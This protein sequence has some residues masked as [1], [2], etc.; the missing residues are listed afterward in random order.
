[1]LAYLD[2]RS[3]YLVLVLL[4]IAQALSM[5]YV[6]QMHWNAPH[7]A[8]WARGYSLIALGLCL[9]LASELAAPALLKTL[10]YALIIWGSMHIAFGVALVSR[11]SPQW[12][13]GQALCLVFLL[14]Y[15]LLYAFGLHGL[16]SIVLFSIAASFFFGYAI[17]SCCTAERNALRRPLLVVAMLSA[18][19]GISLIVHLVA[20]FLD[21]AYPSQYSLWHSGALIIN[22]LLGFAQT[23][24][25]MVIA[26]CRQQM[27][28]QQQATRD[29]LT[30]LFNRRALATLAQR[31]IARSNRRGTLISVLMIDV[32]HF[33]KIND[34]YGHAAGDAVLIAIAKKILSGLRTEDVLARYSGDEFLVMLP[35]TSL[36]NA[37]DVAERIRL[38]ISKI[39]LPVLPQAH[40][41][42]VSVGVAERRG[43]QQSFDELVE[44]ADQALYQAKRGGRNKVLGSKPTPAMVF[45]TQDG[46]QASIA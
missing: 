29:P 40:R 28:L 44:L 39:T 45:Q 15:L 11:K 7:V 31:D 6:Q 2:S 33:K 20:G 35:D 36:K 32:D 46:L 30:N 38:G 21:A 8:K 3:I 22:I 14:A 19:Y 18:A 43:A 1:M 13:L 23:M 26:S 27:D 42:T 10:S 25:L 34:S 17:Y 9:M 5:S 16:S 4:S 12:R 37:C 24:M 41:L